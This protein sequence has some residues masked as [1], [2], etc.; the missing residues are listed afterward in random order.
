MYT[1]GCIEP[2]ELVGASSFSCL[3]VG[4]TGPLDSSSTTSADRRGFSDSFML[5]Y[6]HLFRGF[7][8]SVEDVRG[9][10]RPLWT[11]RRA[12]Q[13][14]QA[15]SGGE[16][17]RLQRPE[18][19]GACAIARALV[20]GVQQTSAWVCESRTGLPVKREKCGEWKSLAVERMKAAWAL[21]T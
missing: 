15:V 1:A 7:N 21:H 17:G 10:A 14:M 18:G 13:P 20:A 2:L 4:R 11:R 6:C 16:E 8:A 9:S 5:L 19:A 3:K 12:R